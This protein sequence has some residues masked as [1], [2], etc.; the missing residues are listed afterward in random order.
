MRGSAGAPGEIRKALFSPSSNLWTET[1]LDLG[2]PSVITDLGDMVFSEK[3]AFF[4]AISDHI[5]GI[6][7]RN[8]IPLSLGGDH[9][10]TFPIVAALSR[11]YPDLEILHL[12][13]HPDLY[14]TFD[15]NPYS[16]ASPMVRILENKMAVRL[17]QVG[18]RTMNAPQQRE[19]A[20]YNTEIIPPDKVAG[21]LP[22]RFSGPLYLSVD[23]D[24]LDPA[25]APGV[26]H[27]EPGGLTTRE[28]IDLIHRIEAPHLVGADLVEM[29]PERDPT[30]RTAMTA[31]K[32]VKELAGALAARP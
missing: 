14:R 19:A 16:H 7:E 28:A 12:D 27:W 9:S 6:L 11:F 26:S 10:I 29:N 3:N 21:S 18:I 17:V 24:V 25:F 1:G 13:A 8:M 22:L 2:D 4:Q 32:L 15:N 20:E 23:L 31:A 5:G 30:G